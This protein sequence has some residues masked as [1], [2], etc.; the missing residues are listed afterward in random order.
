MGSQLLFHRAYPPMVTSLLLFVTLVK[1]S[2]C[3]SVD[4][5]KTMQRPTTVMAATVAV[6]M[7]LMIMFISGLLGSLI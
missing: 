5:I 6:R 4:P 7:D 1:C 2:A 3:A